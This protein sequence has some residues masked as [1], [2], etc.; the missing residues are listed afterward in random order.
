MFIFLSYKHLAASVSCLSVYTNQRSNKFNRA[1]ALLVQASHF[2]ISCVIKTVHLVS[3]Y[4]FLSSYPCDA[5]L[6]CNCRYATCFCSRL[7]TSTGKVFSMRAR[8]Q[9]KPV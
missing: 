5:K 6:I 4:F 1:L 7:F 9:N 8:K 3:A 2:E